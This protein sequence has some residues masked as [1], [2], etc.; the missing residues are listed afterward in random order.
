[1]NEK[2]SISHEV[3]C[4]ASQKNIPLSAFIEVT[5]QC[6]H[7]CYFCYQKGCSTTME[8]SLRQWETLFD[9]LSCQ[10]CLYITLSGG[11]PFMRSDFL[12]IVSAA[13]GRSFAVSIITNGTFITREIA[14]R[15]ADLALTSVGISFHAPQSSLH[16]SLTGVPGSFSRALSA[17]ESLK[18]QKITVIF[19]HSVSKANF[20]Q[21]LLLDAMAHQYGCLL[22]C[23]SLIIPHRGQTASDFALTQHQQSLFMRDFQTVPRSSPTHQKLNWNLHCDAGRSV[24]GITPDGTVVPCILLP[25]GLGNLTSASFSTI[26]QGP[27]VKKFR[28][29][30]QTVAMECRSCS[31]RRACS[32]CY[33]VAYRESPRWNGKSKSL[34]ERTAVVAGKEAVGVP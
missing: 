30:E 16:D 1:M 20:G 25:V 24:C 23:D 33:G 6:N 3:N 21:Y 14:A 17:V 2:S 4:R 8:L 22:E 13:R 10:G 27:T 26:W 5:Y 11:E 28:K 18:E 31:L 19:K 34:C 32:R 15:L 9:E 7:H 12:D 29:Q